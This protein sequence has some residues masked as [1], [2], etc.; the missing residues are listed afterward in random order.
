MKGNIWHLAVVAL[1]LVLL[2]QAVGV[3][4]SDAAQTAGVTNESMTVNYSAPVSVA[5]TSAHAYSDTV[6]IYNASGSELV[7]DTDYTWHSSNGSVSWAN[8][9]NTTDGE[10]AAISYDY[11]YHSD[12]TNGFM[13]LFES[14]AVPL[15]LLFMLVGIGALWSLVFGGGGF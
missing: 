7:A 15:G 13:S 5:N 6:T 3:G 9:T 2:L 1:F 11:E 12:E 10:T 4:Y 8:T 14:M